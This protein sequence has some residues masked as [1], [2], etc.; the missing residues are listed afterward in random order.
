MAKLV[1][2][3]NLRWWLR[4]FN[5][6]HTSW[7]VANFFIDNLKNNEVF[8]HPL[9]NGAKQSS[10]YYKTDYDELYISIDFSYKTGCLIFSDELGKYLNI[11]ITHNYYGDIF[12]IDNLTIEELYEKVDY[13]I[14]II[15]TRKE[16][17]IRIK[18]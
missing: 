18:K 7:N 17:L 2:D 11:P 1:A 10:F 8:I 14:K 15:K 12:I 13:Y 4:V 16:V 3:G 6:S 5:T 9:E